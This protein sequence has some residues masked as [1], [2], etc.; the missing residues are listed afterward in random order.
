MCISRLSLYYIILIFFSWILLK[1]AESLEITYEMKRIDYI[2]LS[3]PINLSHFSS[4]Y[5]MR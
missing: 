4:L 2:I 5:G 3:F 1:L